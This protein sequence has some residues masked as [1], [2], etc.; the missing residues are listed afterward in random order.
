MTPTLNRDTKRIYH[1]TVLEPSEAADL[2]VQGSR[3]HQDW[4]EKGPQTLS[5]WI[6]YFC[7]LETL[8]V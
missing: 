8:L 6:W 3:V 5:L 1:L 4:G 2:P 7:Q